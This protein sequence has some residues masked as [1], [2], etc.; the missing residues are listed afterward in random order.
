MKD[1]VFYK[2][3]DLPK[4]NVLKTNEKRKRKTKPKIINPSQLEGIPPLSL[5]EIHSRTSCLNLTSEVRLVPSLEQV[6]QQ[7][8]KIGLHEIKTHDRC[9]HCTHKNRRR[10]KNTIE[11]C[12]AWIHRFLYFV[13]S[14]RSESYHKYLDSPSPAITKHGNVIRKQLMLYERHT[15]ITFQF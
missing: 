6:R 2:S 13:T 11:W 12:V 15:G 9:G 4:S 5:K 8:I 1:A 14:V 7:G 10:Q 3:L